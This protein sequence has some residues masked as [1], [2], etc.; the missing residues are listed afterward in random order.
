MKLLGKISSGAFVFLL[1]APTIA[2][3]PL[4]FSAKPYISFPPAGFS[5]RW[6]K[7]AL[8]HVWM[9]ALFNSFVVGLTTSLLCILTACFTA[10]LIWRTNIQLRNLGFLAL[11]PLIFPPIVFA[12]GFY[13]IIGE[14]GYLHLILA[15]TVFNFPFTF[16]VVFSGFYKIP[17]DYEKAAMS[18]GASRMEVLRKVIIPLARPSILLG[19]LLTFILSWDES[20]IVLFVTSPTFDTLPK[21]MWQTI[22]FETDLTMAAVSVIMIGFTFLFIYCYRLVKRAYAYT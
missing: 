22:R 20:V 21:R 16:T 1:V 15:H 6:F 10:Y 11:V 19:A 2:V 13:Y 17:K 18:L 9:E 8:S 7:S 3:L 4:A 5:L 14:G 12:V